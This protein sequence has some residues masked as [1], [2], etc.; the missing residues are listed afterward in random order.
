MLHEPRHEVAK[1]VRTVPRGHAKAWRNKISNMS[2][3]IVA[4][5]PRLVRASLL[6]GALDVLEL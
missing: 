1:C 3:T 6:L 5:V 2:V 4:R